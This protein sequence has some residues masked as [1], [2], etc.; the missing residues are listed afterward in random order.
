MSGKKFE[1]YK[2][3]LT[4]ARKK[5]LQEIQIEKASVGFTEQG[6][7]ADI[8]DTQIMNDLLN[9]LSDMD[10][11]KLR[12]IDIALEKIEDGTYGICEGTGKKIPE[13]RLHHIPWTRYSV[14]HAQYLEHERK[15]SGGSIIDR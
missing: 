12:E 6:D 5:I 15:L 7:I 13:A 11:G 2:A 14:E 9:T 4:E 8:A 3:I 1:K 10:Q